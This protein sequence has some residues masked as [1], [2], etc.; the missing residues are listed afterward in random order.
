M[1]S[2]EPR[3]V[4]ITGAA[5]GIGRAMTEALLLDGHCVTLVDTSEA[6]LAI[7]QED[8]GEPDQLHFV[9]GSVAS[10]AD[11][12][13]A[14]SETISRFEKL[15]GIINNAGLGMGSLRPDAEVNVPSIEELTPEIWQRFFDIN[16]LGAIRM[17]RAGIGHLKDAG[18][19]R[20]INNTT[21]FL[22]HHRVQPY[23]GVKAALES[24]SSV[25]ATELENSG[26]SVNVLVPGGPTD[27][28]FVIEIG[29]ERHKMLQPSVMGPPVRWLMSSE[30]DGVNGRRF[31]AGK[32]D[33]SISP[34]AAAAKVSR[35]IGWPD[36]NADVIWNA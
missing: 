24:A 2:T 1:T 29:I 28:G 27:T 25:W 15:H 20:I 19:G 26:V 18:W 22:S 11:C 8:L 32:W 31:S 35:P 17:T 33:T 4:I 30:S 36:L 12:E 5:Q 13:R 14:V 9:L 6:A 23:G 16:V 7:C 34:A 10:E 21:G 3:S